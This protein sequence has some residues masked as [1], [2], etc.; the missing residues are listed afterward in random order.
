MRRYSGKESHPVA[1]AEE[2]MCAGRT[3][4]HGIT[5]V[6][7]LKPEAHQAMS[8]LNVGLPALI[9]GTYVHYSS[10]IPQL[11]SQFC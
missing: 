3:C 10:G 5:V 11:K 6:Q 7:H 9:Q 4:C 2:D 8:Q 1:V